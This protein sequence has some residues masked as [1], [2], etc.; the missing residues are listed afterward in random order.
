MKLLRDLIREEIK[1]LIQDDALFRHLNV[2]GLEPQLDI[3]G[4]EDKFDEPVGACPDCEK[5]WPDPCPGHSTLCS[6]EPEL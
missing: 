2:R 5:T 1:K 4:I 6:V 3:P